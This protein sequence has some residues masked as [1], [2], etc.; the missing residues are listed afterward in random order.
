[1]A[2]LEYSDEQIEQLITG[3]YAGDVDPL[4]L[5]EDLYNSVS[6][7]FNH[8]VEKGFG[9][10]LTKFEFGTPDYELLSELKENIYMFSS[11]RTFSQTYEMSEA[12]YDENE[13]LR[14]LKEFKEAAGEIYTKYNGGKMGEDPEL[15]PGWI[16]TE[17]N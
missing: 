3:I 16:D 13:E 7:Y 5:P 8:A 6:D 14:T 15:K 1:M 9:G 12:L 4:N 10:P 11:A 2:K 17:Y